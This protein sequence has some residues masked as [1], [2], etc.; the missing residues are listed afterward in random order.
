MNG[1]VML[2]AAGVAAIVIYK[3]F[4][5]L[6]TRTGEERPPRQ[7][8]DT[9]NETKESAKIIDI[10]PIVMPAPKQLDVPQDVA[11]QLKAV[12]AIDPKFSTE[13]F[14]VGAKAAY[15]MILTA[16]AAPDLPTLKSLLNTE[17]Y[18]N[19]A[20]AIAHRQAENHTL[21]TTLVG[22]D[23]ANLLEVA[24]KGTV[25]NVTI[26]YCAKLIHVTKN[27]AGAVVEGDATQMIDVVDVWTFS[28]N[29]KSRSPNWLLV[30]TESMDETF[31]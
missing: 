16:F 14:I 5:V 20:A 18:D 8:F 9:K 3:L 29:L 28:R 17:V 10:T 23:K 11:E 6:G 24:L 25:A 12:L 31:S 7:I 21:E 15:E 22:I 13:E 27:E 1:L 26:Q 4:S 30:A 2:I 19:F